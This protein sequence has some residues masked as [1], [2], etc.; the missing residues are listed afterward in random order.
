LVGEDFRHVE[1][2][3][4]IIHHPEKSSEPRLSVPL[5]EKV[6]VEIANVPES[7][8]KE[9][10]IFLGAIPKLLHILWGKYKGIYMP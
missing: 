1:N 10:V 4:E 8:T 9:Y 3:N 5:S 2:S 7:L 6:L